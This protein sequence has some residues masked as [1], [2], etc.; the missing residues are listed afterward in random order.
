MVHLLSSL[1]FFAGVIHFEMSFKGTIKG[2][3]YF[4]KLYL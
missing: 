4:M 2:G 3:S 1:Q